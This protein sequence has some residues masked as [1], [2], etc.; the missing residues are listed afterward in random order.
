MS[1]AIHPPSVFL[2]EN[3][4]LCAAILSEIVGRLPSKKGPFTLERFFAV[5]YGRLDCLS[6]GS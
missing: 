6:P 3:R 1:L 5:P 4:G 2:P